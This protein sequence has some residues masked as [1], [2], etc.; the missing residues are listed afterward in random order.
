MGGRAG[1]VLLPIAAGGL[2]A[3]GGYGLAGKGPLASLLGPGTTAAATGDAAATPTVQQAA[4]AV[5]PAAAGGAAGTMPTFSPEQ[6]VGMGLPAAAAAMAPGSD[7]ALQQQAQDVTSGMA[8]QLNTA[9]SNF[10]AGGQGAM[11]LP[12]EWDKNAKQFA[13]G[14]A[15]QLTGQGPLPGAASATTPSG[16][17]TPGGG[18][19]V[20]GLASN[21][22]GAVNALGGGGGGQQQPQAPAP[23]ARRPVTPAQG[24]TAAPTVQRVPRGRPARTPLGPA[25]AGPMGPPTPPGGGLFG[26]GP[27]APQGASGGLYDMPTQQLMKLLSL[28]GGQL[29]PAAA[30]AG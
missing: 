29:G 5:A 13:Q 10:G 3:L 9:S 12:G 15:D 26:L 14:Y 21:A 25:G 17:T 19:D 18:P 23:P 4:G 16:A 28:V 7:A 24:G 2:G 6:L 11:P 1:Q 30:L 8:N 27:Q 22:L 20:G